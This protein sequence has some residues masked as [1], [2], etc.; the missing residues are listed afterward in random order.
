MTATQN[1][2]GATLIIEVKLPEEYAHIVERSPLTPESDPEFHRFALAMVVG[3]FGGED[4]GPLPA[5]EPATMPESTP[6]PFEMWS[7]H[8]NRQHALEAA[9]EVSRFVW[10]A[11]HDLIDEAD[12]LTLVASARG[13]MV[14]IDELPHRTCKQRIADL[15]NGQPWPCHHPQWAHVDGW[16]VGCEELARTYNSR[17]R[18]QHDLSKRLALP[19]DGGA[20]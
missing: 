2:Q 14:A 19:A 15:T 8:Q 18:A 13:F 11:D 6:V 17:V 12:L 1:E 10:R 7:A 20:A 5:P 9:T 4:R 16:C 3:S